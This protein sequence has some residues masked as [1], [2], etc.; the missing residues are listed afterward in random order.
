MPNFGLWYARGPEVVRAAKPASAFSKGDLLVFDSSSSLSRAPILVGDIAIAGVANSDSLSSFNNEI[1]YTVADPRTVFWSISS[2]V[3]SALTPGRELDF[4]ED[5]A[6]RPYV[7]DSELTSMVLVEEIEAE[8]P[9]P[10]VQSRVLVRFLATQ[11]TATTRLEQ[12]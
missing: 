10:S 1:P 3:G 9:D 6:G 8:G 11:S 7:N 4:V 12:Y 5:N 2:T